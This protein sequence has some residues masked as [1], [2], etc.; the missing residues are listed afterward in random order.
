MPGELVR[1]SG[2]GAIGYLVDVG[3]FNLLAY[4]PMARL[5]PITAKVAGMAVA[6]I[7]T[8][9]GNRHFV[10]PHRRTRSAVHELGLFVLVAAVGVG[11]SVGVL[12]ISHYVLGLTSQ[13]ADNVAANVIGFGLATVFRFFAYRTFV[14][15]AGKQPPPQ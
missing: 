13:L 15:P 14:F 10:F 4:G 2:V 7:V 3:V 8:W 6:T 5:D 11:L 1:Y 9:L 12:A